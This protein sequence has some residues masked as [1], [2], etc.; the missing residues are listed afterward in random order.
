[1]RLFATTKEQDMTTRAIIPPTGQ[2]SDDDDLGLHGSNQRPSRT[3]PLPH[4]GFG[5]PGS[6]R[7]GGRRGSWLAG[8]VMLGD[9]LVTVEPVKAAMPA[10]SISCHSTR[11][12]PQRLMALERR[13][14][15]QAGRSGAAG[16]RGS[17]DRDP[18]VIEVI[19]TES[20]EGS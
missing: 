5:L 7:T 3:A 17:A 16:V 14:L 9:S 13:R 6:K 8:W 1:M 10:G 20:L 2:Q 18:S 11:R 12:G 4:R 19:A 15:D